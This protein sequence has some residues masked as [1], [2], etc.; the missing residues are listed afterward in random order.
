MTLKNE[1]QTFEE[2]FLIKEIE[3]AAWEKI[4]GENNFIWSEKI[5]ERNAEK[6][7][8]AKLCENVEVYWTKRLLHMFWD[9]INWETLSKR[10]LQNF[11]YSTNTNIWSIIKEFESSWDWHEL[12]CYATSIP[13]EILAEYADKWD[14]KA[15]IQNNNLDWSFELFERFK[16]YIPI[17]DIET[18]KGTHLWRELVEIDKKIIV[19]K[20]LSEN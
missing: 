18:F 10:I 17:H 2:E 1:L 14:W 5:I 7:N 9:N 8:W 3:N 13:N 15:L 19:G 4:S 20:I 11:R 12:S 6:I 16:K